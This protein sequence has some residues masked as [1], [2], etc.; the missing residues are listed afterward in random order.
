MPIQEDGS[1]DRWQPNGDPDKDAPPMP[2][3]AAL[4]PSSARNVPHKVPR[5]RLFETA[6]GGIKQQFKKQ[7]SSGD[8][9]R[10][11]KRNPVKSKNEMRPNDVGMEANLP[12]ASLPGALS[13]HH[14][15]D[16]VFVADSFSFEPES[17]QI[18]PE[19]F[20]LPVQRESSILDRIRKPDGSEF[21]EWEFV[22]DPSRTKKRQAEER[23]KALEAPAEMSEVESLK[24]KIARLEKEVHNVQ[25]SH[26][27][28]YPLPPRPYP[29]DFDLCSV[30]VKNVHYMANEEVVAAHFHSCQPIL[31]IDFAKDPYGQPKGFCFIQF[32]NERSVQQALELDKSLLLGRNI[33]VVR[34]LSRPPMQISKP[35]TGMEWKKRQWI[36]GALPSRPTPL[37]EEWNNGTELDAQEIQD[38]TIDTGS[39]EMP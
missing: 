4:D 16:P 37:R 13:F 15:Q 22:R 20:P 10:T 24:L 14:R 17:I 29:H 23:P 3:D 32:S 21:E 2:H 30:C 27:V 25:A 31:R 12:H 19:P 1:F 38:F 6:L 7:E 33:T 35:M 28:P 5:S 36:P 8:E 11:E 9:S 39:Q 18:E 34:K 26:S